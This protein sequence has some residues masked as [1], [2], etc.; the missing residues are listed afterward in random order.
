MIVVI[1]MLVGVY[2]LPSLALLFA[3]TAM[4][5]F[6]GLMMEVHNRTTHRVNWTAFRFGSLAGIVPWVVIGLYLLA[7]ASRSIGDVPTFVYGIYV[8]L[9]LWFN[10]FAVNTPA[11]VQAGRPLARLLV[12]GADVHY[13]QPHGEVRPRLAGARRHA[14]RC[15]NGSGWSG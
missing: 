12:R 2:D 13:P 9:F 5:I 6:C 4:M 11:P 8:S 10:C 3:I 7:P 14:A 15:L 1:A